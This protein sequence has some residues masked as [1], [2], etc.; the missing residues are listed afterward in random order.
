MSGIVGFTQ[1]LS[2]NQAK[3]LVEN[4]LR[5]LEPEQDRFQQVLYHTENV[6]LGSLNLKS[7]GGQ[8]QLA[9]TPS[10][11]TC[12]LAIGEIYNAA[13]LREA[14]KSQGFHPTSNDL[15]E[16][17]LCLFAAFGADFAIKV[18][19]AFA[20]AIWD[21]TQQ[22]LHVITDRLGLY[23]IYYAQT[24]RG[25]IFASGVRA[26]LA[27]SAM[28]RATDPLA[29]AEFLTFD[30][31]LG[32]R[33]LLS[34]VR[35][36][37]QASILT[38]SD[39]KIQIHPYWRIQY[40]QLYQHR[41]QADYLEELIYHL[42]NAIR[43]QAPDQFPT[44]L[45]LSGGLDSR[46]LLA[47]L[48]EISPIEQLHTFTWGIPGCDDARIAKELAGKIGSQHHFF[49]LKP[50]YLLHKAREAVRLTDGMANIIN[51]HAL[52]T[53]EEE[54]QYAQVIYKG[55]LGDAMMGFA[56]QRPFW[57]DYDADTAEAVHLSVHHYQG[58][59]YY[60]RAEQQK[61]F[62][63]SFKQQVGNGVFEAYRQGMLQANHNQMVVQRLYFDFTQRVP[64]HT[65]NGVKVVRSRS[66]VRLPFADN[67]LIEFS[68]TIPPGFQYERQLMRLAFLQTFPKLAQIPISDT[69]LPMVACARDIFL[70]SKQLAQWHVNQRAGK[71]INWP[72]RRPYKDY[73]NW[74]RTLMHPWIEETLLNPQSLERGYFKP[75]Y[76]RN[77]VNTH[78]AGQDQTIKLGQL[79]SIE[80]WH[81]QF[82]D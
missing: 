25:V 34:N 45:L 48:A 49:E 27:D 13:E 37:P 35:L 69:N 47:L 6:G 32:N 50:D 56:V 20:A 15:S 55:F 44:G 29:I 36:L 18:N 9:W 53:L 10:K 51:L 77:L 39:Q 70:R 66:L 54:S 23:P 63:D 22:K 14:A 76:V 30:H 2:P 67:D 7:L 8:P 38:V 12:A 41:K 24:P 1:D 58:V 80:L 4:M 74:F 5:A 64:R 81:K 17:I 21:T 79:L 42:R 72:N 75:E 78:M 65:L 40:P 52:A 3:N 59:F 33:T 43:R 31:V 28:D 57:A 60:D 82:I 26:L 68:L 71:W 73:A 46:F 19:G 61:I 62:S 16:L 11:N